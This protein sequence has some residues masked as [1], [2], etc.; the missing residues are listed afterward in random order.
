MPSSLWF[1]V[2]FGCMCNYFTEG[3]ALICS[4]IVFM[5]RIIWRA[6]VFSLSTDEQGDTGRA[7]LCT[8]FASH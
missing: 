2:E 3:A 1:V 5:K 8:G 4:L 7:Y 6:K